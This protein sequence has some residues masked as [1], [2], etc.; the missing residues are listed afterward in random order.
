MYLS[1]TPCLFATDSEFCCPIPWISGDV[2][3]WECSHDFL[4]DSI[5]APWFP[6][7]GHYH[8]FSLG[9]ETC[10]PAKRFQVL[11]LN[12]FCLSPVRTKDFTSLIATTLQGFKFLVTLVRQGKCRSAA[13]AENASPVPRRVLVKRNQAALLCMSRGKCATCAIP[14]GPAADTGWCPESSPTPFSPQPLSKKNSK[15][16]KS[17]G[18]LGEG[19]GGGTSA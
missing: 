17:R 19:G 2:F 15:T 6:P 3:Q 13:A 14:L 9:R 5:P 8:N 18:G 1:S 11:L 10:I 4:L 12:Q 7:M 16:K